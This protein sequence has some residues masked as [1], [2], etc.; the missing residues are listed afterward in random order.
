MNIGQGE[1][2]AE[3]KEEKAIIGKFIDDFT[4]EISRLA[5]IPYSSLMKREQKG[6]KIDGDG[7]FLEEWRSEAMD[8]LTKIGNLAEEGKTFLKNHQENTR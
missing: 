1:K 4:S 6:G 3:T 2:A 5:R 7:K 8:I